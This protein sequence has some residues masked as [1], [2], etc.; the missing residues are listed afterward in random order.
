VAAGAPVRVG[1]DVI[2]R[3]AV[4]V[5]GDD[6]LTPFLP[7]LPPAAGWPL[8]RPGQRLRFE[9]RNLAFAGGLDRWELAGSFLGAGRPHWQDYAAAAD[10]SAVL[11]AT[12]PEPAGFAVLVQTIF[13]DDYRGAAVTF[14]GE[15]RTRDL[16][17]HAGLHLAAG[18]THEPPGPHLRDRGTRSLAAPG[19]SE[20]T[21][22][23]VTLAVPGD[24]AIIRF[25]ISLTG[26]GSVEL[27]N[28][29]L[30]RA[31]PEPAE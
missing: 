7:P 12:V 22:H 11:A 30:G 4:P 26:R 19:S 16:A 18:H 5:Q 8:R 14:R 29:E 17:D 28:A 20:W 25:G 10:G 6:L 21:W 24:A 13:A 23:H 9:P 15:L 1:D 2:D 27:R 31:R 3:L